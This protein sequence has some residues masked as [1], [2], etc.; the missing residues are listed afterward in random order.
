MFIFS[1]N[2]GRVN[3]VVIVSV[4]CSEWFF[5]LWCLVFLLVDCVVLVD[6]VWVI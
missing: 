6:I 3:D 2:I 4:C 5:V 1:M